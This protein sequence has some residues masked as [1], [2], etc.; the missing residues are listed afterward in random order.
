MTWTPWALF[1]TPAQPARG[2]AS[3]I[4]SGGWGGTRC[5]GVYCRGAAP[6][7]CMANAMQGRQRAAV[8]HHHVRGGREHALHNTTRTR[9]LLNSVQLTWSLHGVRTRYAVGAQQAPRTR[10]HSSTGLFAM[11][12]PDRPTPSIPVCNVIQYNM[13]C[14]AVSRLT[15]PVMRRRMTGQLSRGASSGARYRTLNLLLAT[16][17][18]C[19]TIFF[20]L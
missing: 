6:R 16:V 8:N 5:A 12:R 1:V 13:P 11:K 18:S 19:S 3:Q 17:S 14:L 9:T 10:T 4:L 20:C 15:A 7:L 2:W